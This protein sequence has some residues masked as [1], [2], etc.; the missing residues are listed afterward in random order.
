MLR[1][2]RYA[3][4]WSVFVINWFMIRAFIVPARVSCIVEVAMKCPPL[5]TALHTVYTAWR[6]LGLIYLMQKEEEVSACTKKE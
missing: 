3:A 6:V 2:A 4:G 1:M 5:M